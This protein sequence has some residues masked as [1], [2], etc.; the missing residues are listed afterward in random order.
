MCQKD[1]AR[2]ERE[3]DMGREKEQR[4]GDMGRIEQQQGEKGRGEHQGD[5]GLGVDLVISDIMSHKSF[6]PVGL[7]DASFSQERQ[8]ESQG[9]K[10]REREVEI[11]KERKEESQKG[12]KEIKIKMRERE[13]AESAI[14]HVLKC[15]R[16]KER[17]QEREI[18]YECDRRGRETSRLLERKGETQTRKTD[19]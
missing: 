2:R 12:K 7:S 16:D 5:W 8:R 18:W 4:E 6:L 13:R 10:E 11:G 15:R 1:W 9:Q 3:G 19:Y 14:N 17:V